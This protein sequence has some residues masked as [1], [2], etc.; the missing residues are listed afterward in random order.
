MLFVYSN[1]SDVIFEDQMY[2]NS[3]NGS[4]RLDK[5][6]HC[7]LVKCSVEVLCRF[8]PVGIL[9]VR[10]LQAWSPI[11]AL[12]NYGGRNFTPGC[13]FTQSTASVIEHIM[14]RHRVWR[15]RGAQS[16]EGIVKRNFSAS[17][18]AKQQCCQ[19]SKSNTNLLWLIIHYLQLNS[20]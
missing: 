16:T 13:P 18:V 11:V 8:F 20:K 19:I 3:Q 14:S 7:F 12:G 6:T 17:V 4:T 9:R 2:L 10:L 1:S 15:Y 5:F